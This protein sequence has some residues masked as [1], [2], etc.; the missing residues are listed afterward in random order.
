[1]QSAMSKKKS[2]EQPHPPPQVSV[3][4]SPGSFYPHFSRK[5]LTIF[6][7]HMCHYLTVSIINMGQFES[8]TAN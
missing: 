3:A 7:A 1:M 4:Q 8:K 2:V 5:V 6:V